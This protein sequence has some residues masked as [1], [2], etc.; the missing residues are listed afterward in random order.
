[1]SM[2]VPSYTCYQEYSWSRSRPMRKKTIIIKFK[3]L[4]PVKAK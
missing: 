1:M 2:F 4:D 3:N